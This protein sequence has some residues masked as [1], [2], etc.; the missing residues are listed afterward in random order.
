MCVGMCGCENIVRPMGVE[1][2]R[3][4]GGTSF[5]GLVGRGEDP[6]V[7]SF[8]RHIGWP[9]MRY[10]KTDLTYKMKIPEPWK[11]LSRLTKRTTICNPRPRYVT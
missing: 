8:L 1:S 4:G 9:E 11:A 6:S 7:S 3:C 2:A 5:F 10:T